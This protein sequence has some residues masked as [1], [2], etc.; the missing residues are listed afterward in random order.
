M[1]KF[2]FVDSSNNAFKAGDYY[3]A[4]PDPSI[5]LTLLSMVME[6]LAAQKV[7]KLHLLYMLIGM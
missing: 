4:I 7:L 6:W 1:T 5:L 2:V 3:I